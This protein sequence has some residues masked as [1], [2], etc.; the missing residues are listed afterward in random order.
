MA[1][2]LSIDETNKI[3]IA[4]G[5]RPIVI[6]NEASE[7]ST[8]TESKP[9]NA[10]ESKNDIAHRIR[11]AKARIDRSRHSKQLKE[12]LTT[13]EWLGQIDF[14]VTSG[15]SATAVPKDSSAYTSEDISHLKVAPIDSSSFQ[16]ADSSAILTL[17]DTS[18]LQDSDDALEVSAKK[19][20]KSKQSSLRMSFAD[21]TE[22][23]DQL[24][25]L[26]NL[27]QAIAASEVIEDTTQLDL[28]TRAS[29]P[30]VQTVY[31]LEE[32]SE[33]LPESDYKPQK[34]KKRKRKD[35]SAESRQ[36]TDTDDFIEAVKANLQ[37]DAEE[38][39]DNAL[40][41]NR[42]QALKQRKKDIVA[43]MKQAEEAERNIAPMADSEES[44]LVIDGTK[45]FVESFEPGSN[46]E[47]TAVDNDRVA[48]NENIDCVT[49]DEFTD[50]N[51]NTDANVANT[52]DGGL[53]DILQQ[54]TKTGV[55]HNDDEATE[56]LKRQR[57]QLRANHEMKLRYAM[58]AREQQDIKESQRDILKRLTPKEKEELAEKQKKEMDKVNAELARERLKNYKPDVKLEYRNEEGKLLSTKE[59]YKE[60]S[61]KFHGNGKRKSRK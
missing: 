46:V 32:T 31:T 27:E 61:H 2:E 36:T 16:S 10:T 15:D 51:N 37:L 11:Q 54:L 57:E 3:R 19:P 50:E 38:D 33:R 17:R 29:K 5:L 25:T 52:K 35:R 20:R 13:A 34:I 42:L 49:T 6:A 56:K 58:K 18:V 48:D 40:E 22:D 39:Y 1:R 53:A 59:A 4:L 47:Q 41:H 7:P 9:E 23:T 21:H 55:I 12:P 45:S 24:V 43:L 26:A 44:D 14:T 28:G 60:L 30:L 8:T